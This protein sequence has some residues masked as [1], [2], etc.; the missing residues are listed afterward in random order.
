MANL[1]ESVLS[2]ALLHHQVVSGDTA[3]LECDAAG[4]VFVSVQHAVPYQPLRNSI[5]RA[6][7]L[8]SKINADV[9]KDVVNA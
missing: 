8:L 7:G 4:T 5:V 6:D 3:H 1:V 2:D 9:Q